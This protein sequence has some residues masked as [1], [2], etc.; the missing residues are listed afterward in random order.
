[1]K[2]THAR[3]LIVVATALA[4]F[5]LPAVIA[6]PD[7][8]PNSAES[9]I[10]GFPALM[11]A[12]NSLP[13]STATCIT[14]SDLQ[15]G[16]FEPRACPE[17]SSTTQTDVPLTPLNP[18]HDVESVPLPPEGV[19]GQGPFPTPPVNVPAGTVAGFFSGSDYCVALTPQNQPTVSSCTDYGP[20]NAFL[21]PFGPIPLLNVP[22][23]SVGP[24]P[25]VGEGELG[26]TP[27]EHVPA[28]S[29]EAESTTNWVE[30]H[31]KRRS[32]TAGQEIWEP[33]DLLNAS[34]ISWFADNGDKTTLHIHFHLYADGE[35]FQEVDQ[36][37]PYV[38]QA[39]AALARTP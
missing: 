36:H 10:C 2:T 24:T 29:F 19:P 37:V 30:S 14:T 15:V 5:G 18:S 28:F 8:I 38:G 20:L 39:L 11:N 6:E 16:A 31:L 17:C 3:H 22:S 26:N 23:Q 13:D 34:E 21:Q 1:M 35:E 12:I 27:S 4:M 7:P 25:G 9:I 32:A 33:V